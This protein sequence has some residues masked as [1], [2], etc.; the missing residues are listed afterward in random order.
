M[1]KIVIVVTAVFYLNN[2]AF[3]QEEETEKKQE[4]KFF[5]E[6]NA[7]YLGSERLSYN[8]IEKTLSSNTSALGAWK[9]GNAFKRANTGMKIATGV[10]LGSGVGFTT[11]LP[12]AIL[13][14]SGDGDFFLVSIY[15]G[16]T[17]FSAGIIT[18]IMIP[19]T[20]AT[21]K[22]CYSDAADTYNRGLQSKTAV[23]LHIGVTGNGFGLNL[24]F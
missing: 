18:G 6:D 2:M 21:Y 8:E 24:K 22:S 5:R 20:K 11:I 15:M 16:I 17:F 23:S 12:L 3:S 19:I 9:R 4:L 13:L 10:L 1:K 7:F 14:S